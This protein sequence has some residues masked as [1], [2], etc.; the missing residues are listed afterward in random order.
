MYFWTEKLWRVKMDKLH[1]NPTQNY[2]ENDLMEVTTTV[3]QSVGNWPTHHP[4]SVLG[5]SNS[6]TAP[7]VLAFLVFTLIG[8]LVVVTV[9]TKNKKSDKDKQLLHGVPMSK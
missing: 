7:L 1:F 4:L 8:F 3:Y 6:G 5:L 2:D 9:K